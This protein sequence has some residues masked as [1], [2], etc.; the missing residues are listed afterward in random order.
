MNMAALQTYF[1][2]FHDAIKMEDENEILREKRSILITKL[3]DRLKEICEDPPT[4]VEFNK[5]GYAMN[6]GIKPLNGD[7]DIDVGLEF[8]IN[9]GDYSNPVEVKQ[10]VFDALYG[11]TD[12][13]KIRKPCVTVQYHQDDD[14]L[15]HVDFAVYA[16]DGYTKNIYLARGKPTS[17]EDEKKWE[18]DDPIGLIKLIRELFA[19]KKDREQFRRVIR[20]LKRWKDVK[21]SLDGHSAPIGVGLTVCGY[22]WFSVSKVSSDPVKMSYEYNDLAATL[23]LVNAMI[24]KF[25]VVSIEDGKTLYRLRSDLP[26]QPYNDLFQKMSDIQMTDFKEKLERLR[27]ALIAA[28]D[29]TDP[30]EACIILRRQFGDDFPVPELEETAQKRGPAIISSSSSA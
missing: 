8:Q 17:P 11:H 1:E 24:A 28:R 25:I 19:D 12:D 23:S 16:R 7:Y 22:H 21:F 14:S 5:G 9:K 2:K 29:E 20:D 26:V 6:L 18:V 4:F 3:R 13:V 30:R 10:W 27:D 15:Y